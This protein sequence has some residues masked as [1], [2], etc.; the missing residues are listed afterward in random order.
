LDAQNKARSDDSKSRA[1][2]VS[3]RRISVGIS[4]VSSDKDSWKIGT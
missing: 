4:S 1:A 3:R 2:S